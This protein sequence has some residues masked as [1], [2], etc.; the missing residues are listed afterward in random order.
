MKRQDVPP[1]TAPFRHQNLS[2]GAFSRGLNAIQPFQAT[3]LRAAICARYAAVQ[4]DE[5]VKMS[6]TFT[7][8]ILD[9]DT[10]GRD[11]W[12]HFFLN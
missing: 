12:I 4:R 3:W 1:V 5:M 7:P 8:V 2:D 9:V 10:K 6:L 11:K